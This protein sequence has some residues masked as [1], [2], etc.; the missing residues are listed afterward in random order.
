MVLQAKFSK[1]IDFARS[2]M[3]ALPPF[4]VPTDLT[5]SHMFVKATDMSD[6]F[7]LQLSEDDLGDAVRAVSGDTE[8]VSLA[9]VMHESREESRFCVSY[10]GHG[11]A[12]FG[13]VHAMAASI[14]VFVTATAFS[15]LRLVNHAHGSR[16]SF[17]FA[18]RKI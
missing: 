17:A 10:A 12:R 18:Y 4:E 15:L 2:I 6:G 7:Y 16:H 1:Y 9:K 11:I 3:R 8:D 13:G 5:D 14:A